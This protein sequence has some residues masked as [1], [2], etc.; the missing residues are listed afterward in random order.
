VGV[1]KN[2]FLCDKRAM[3]TNW[4]D[5]IKRIEAQG[6]TQ[7]DIAAEVGTSQG[8]ISDLRTGRRGK[9]IG[10]EIGRNLTAMHDRLCSPPKT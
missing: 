7:V 9:R 5:I 10:F 8:H 2:Y 3:N 6:K 1:D 4:Q